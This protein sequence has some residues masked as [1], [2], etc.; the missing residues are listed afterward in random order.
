MCNKINITTGNGEHI[1]FVDDEPLISDLY[2]NFL[3]SIVYKITV[4]DNGDE[5]LRLFRENSD[6]YDCIVTDYTMSGMS[7]LTLIFA[8]RQLDNCIPIILYS[9]YGELLHVT[10]EANLPKLF[11]LMKPCSLRDMSTLIKEILT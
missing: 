4:V 8:I 1:L 3:R 7:G 9:G 6:I 10:K 5:A 11:T 2:Q